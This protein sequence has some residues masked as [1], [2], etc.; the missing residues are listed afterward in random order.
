LKNDF[1]IS[2]M[3]DFQNPALGVQHSGLFNLQEEFEKEFAPARTFPS[4]SLL[5]MPLSLNWALHVPGSKKT[6]MNT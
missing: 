3:I 5:I 1:R 4:C 6:A 2:L